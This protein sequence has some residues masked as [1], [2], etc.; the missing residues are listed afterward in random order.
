MAVSANTLF[1]FTKRHGFESIL[2]T[3]Q[4]WPSYSKEDFSSV[5]TKHSQYRFS[6]VPMVCFC[7]LRLKQLSDPGLSRHTKDFG[8]FGFGFKKQWGIKNSISPVLYVHKK[9]KS[10]SFCWQSLCLF[11]T[12]SLNKQTPAPINKRHIEPRS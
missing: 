2:A 5:L 11:L 9:S 7:D 4:F 12:R 6:Y 1:H 8:Q 10:S 3:K